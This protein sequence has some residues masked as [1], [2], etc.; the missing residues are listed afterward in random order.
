MHQL[1]RALNSLIPCFCVE[2]IH[3]IDNSPDDSLSYFVR[4][5][6][7][8]SYT[9]TK[10]N[11]GF[12]AGHN[13]ALRRSLSSKVKYHLV[14]NAD[15]YF[16]YDVIDKLIT[17]MNANSDVGLVMPK[18]FYPNGD[19]QYLCKLLPNPFD[20]II[21]RFLPNI[22]F[23]KNLSDKF[24]LRRSGY[25]RLLNVPY[26]SGCFMFLRVSALAEV[27]IFDERFFMYPEDIDLSRRIH[28]KFRTIF[29]P[30]AFVFHEHGKAS[31]RSKK[32]LFIHA[33][34]LARYFN[35]WG[36]FFDG[37]RKKINATVLDSLSSYE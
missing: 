32:M 19:V 21:R 26:L 23:F 3:L 27:G 36:W 17:F 18:V 4:L 7:R 28:E 20:L 31:Y 13:I 37:K 11:I 12:G 33:I 29:Y 1:E 5:D 16:D 35:K 34:N 14:L 8:I 25:D 9:H 30:D 15:V 2:R 10:Q 24:E 22:Y 6:N